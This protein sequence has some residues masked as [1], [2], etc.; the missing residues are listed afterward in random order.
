MMEIFYSD[1]QNTKKDIIIA[2]DN[3]LSTKYNRGKALYGRK[4]E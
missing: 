3:F 2:W 4:I 1:R